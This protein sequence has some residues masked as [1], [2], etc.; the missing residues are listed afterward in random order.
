MT[1]YIFLMHDTAAD[2]PSDAWTAYIERLSRSGNMRGGSA[3]GEGIACRKDGEIAAITPDLS[4]YIR[5]ETENLEAARALL[6]GN[7]VYEAGGTVE[8][9]ELPA[10]N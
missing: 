1:D 5:I 10:T 9:R 8:I 4:G 6:A 7:P 3:I 2:I